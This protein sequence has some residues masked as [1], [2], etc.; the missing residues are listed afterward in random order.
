MPNPVLNLPPW[1]RQMNQEPRHFS[2]LTEA[3]DFVIAAA[4]HNCDESREPETGGPFGA[5]ILD[6][7]LN[8]VSLGVN[9]VVPAM[10]SIYHAEMVALLL[11]QRRLG[12]HDLSAYGDHVLVTSCAPCAMCLGAI[13]FAGVKQVICGARGD[14]AEAIGFDEGDKPAGWTE[15][16]RARGIA[17]EEDLCRDRAVALFSAYQAKAGTIY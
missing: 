3:M 17:V 7:Q 15:R 16:L 5:A 2:S 4:E 12:G 14:D 9:R 8:L 11:A 1:L 10:G 6:A 13:P